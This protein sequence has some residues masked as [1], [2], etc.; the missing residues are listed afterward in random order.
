MSYPVTPFK[1]SDITIQPQAKLC[2]QKLL[3]TEEEVLTT[4]NEWENGEDETATLAETQTLTE[5]PEKAEEIPAFCTSERT[6]PE[7]NIIICIKYSTTIKKQ[8][9]KT[10]IHA[11]VHWVSTRP[12]LDF[13]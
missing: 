6:F 3:I 13:C 12:P 11:S 4:I 5:Y 7:R 10:K 2:M 9:G 8:Q 1:K